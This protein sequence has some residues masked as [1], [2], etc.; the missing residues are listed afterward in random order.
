[1]SGA[2]AQTPGEWTW[3]SGVTSA[4]YV[5]NFGTLGMPDFNEKVD[6]ALRPKLI[7]RS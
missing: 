1:M 5:G 6:N 7:L 3:M 2:Y 4:N